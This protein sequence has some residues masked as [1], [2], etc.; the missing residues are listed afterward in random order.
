MNLTTPLTE[1]KGV[2]DNV[3]GKLKILGLKTVQD[4][5]DNYPKRYE[6]YSSVQPI[7]SITP[8]PVTIKGAI[9]QPTGRTVRR[10]LHITEAVLS[11]ETSSVRII[12]FNQPYRAASLKSDAEYYVSGI[13]EFKSGRLSIMNPSIELA[14]KFNVNTARIIPIYRQTKGLKSAV[15]RKLFKQILPAIGSLPE[16]LP[17][18]LVSS[19]GLIDKAKANHDIH[20]PKDNEALTNAEKRLGFEEV[21][22]L[23]LAGLLNKY[24]LHKQRALAVEFNEAVARDFVAKLPFKLT[25][26]QKRATWQ[27]FK[28]IEKE[29]PMNRLI[30][31]DVGSGKTVVA[32]MAAVMAIERGFQVALM[33]PTEI[34]A[35]QH[36]GS[37]Y[38]LLKPVGMAQHVSLLV[39]GMTSPQKK[40]SQSAIKNGKARF[41]IGTHA[42]IQ[43]K[44]AMQNLGLVIIDE[45]HRF[46]VEQ[47][48]ALLTKAKHAVHVLS[49]TATPIPRSLALTLYGE[50]DVSILSEKPAK[51]LDIETE[52]VPASSRNKLIENVKTELD[53]GR[54]CFW[55][56]S[57]IEESE[58]DFP[59]L[60]S[61]KD[62]HSR[63]ISR[64]FKGYKVGLLHGSMKAEDKDKV[65]TDFSKG[66]IDLLVSTTVVE[67]GV[68]IPNASVMVNEN[69]ER[70]GL[71]QLHQLRGRVGRGIYQ[72]YCYLQ[73]ANAQSATRRLQIL[74][75]SNDGFKLAEYDLEL[76]GPGAV[77]GT[78]QHGALDLKI[79]KLT[80]RKLIAAARK[81]AQEFIDKGE[82]LLEY[83]QLNKRVQQK[84]AIT[85]LN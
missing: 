61:V 5:I 44:V 68:D 25:D 84:R 14:D 18:W 9:K 81:S 54:Q 56:C 50:L 23:T 66:N 67:V 76:R 6:D 43:E 15:I 71:A 37:L 73:L 26:D 47:R 42:L 20:F 58:E 57:L 35:R 64:E 53:A 17:S 41:I 11:D 79:A 49:L 4:L 45:Q 80:D 52:L 63:F 22:V 46:G 36:A 48:K 55:I 31:G 83:K 69:P 10:G 70:F 62:L 7:N 60:V 1:L 3:A 33:A 32:A 78:M 30:E 28:D 19:Q 8:G 12:W 51:R 2:G 24:E 34:L 85:N 13:F 40:L 39:G 82:N 77:Y 75:N 29:Q 21:F 74:K 38:E 72:S 27:V 65:M 59:D 16:S